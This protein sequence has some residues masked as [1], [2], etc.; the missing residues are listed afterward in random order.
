MATMN[1]ETLPSRAE[2]DV[3]ESEQ[4]IFNRLKDGPGT[5]GWVVLHSVS[6]PGRNKNSNPREI[7]FLIMVPGGGVICLEVKGDSYKI[8][9]DGKW[10]R[11]HGDGSAE[12]ESPINQ[13]KKAMDA[14]KAHLKRSAPAS[15]KQKI[16]RLP[17]W[18]GL[19]FTSGEWPKGDPRPGSL[20]FCD[21]ETSQDQRKLCQEL[22]DYAESLP[23]R[24]HDK[25][26][27]DSDTIAEILNFLRP[28]TKMEYIATSSSDLAEINGQLLKLTKEQFRA[29]R[30][31]QAD[32]GEIRNERVL[33]EGAAG[34]GKTMLAEQ[35]AKLRT[36]AGD[37]VALVFPNEVLA[38]WMRSK[39]PDVY[40]VGTVRDVLV[41]GQHVDESFREN[42]RRS[43]EATA[44]EV[45][46]ELIFTSHA[47]T[48]TEKM[49][50]KDLQWDYLIVD[51][52]QYFDY[53]HTLNMLDMALKGGLERGRWAMF[54]DFTFQNWS[55][56]MGR[57]WQRDWQR[58]V[59]TGGP[60]PL[61]QVVN[62]RECLKALCPGTNGGRGW[63]EALPLEINCRNTLPIAHAATRVVGIGTPQVR[64]SQVPG[65]PVD[66]YYWQE[67]SEM[68]SL[69]EE[70]FKR[71]HKAGVNPRQATVLSDVV[72][73]SADHGKWY[74]PWSLWDY[75]QTHVVR[76]SWEWELG[77]YVPN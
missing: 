58:G 27:L 21:R 71:L 68:R 33:F 77:Q 19:A 74:G 67:L 60:K 64:P 39:L 7:D 26:P 42:F 51:E 35:L 49:W 66:F 13:S 32:G 50:E 2:T 17:I 44:D 9:K 22:K 72:A 43:L 69:L 48:A 61:F 63:V 3:P 36:R 4:R 29:L 75:W 41:E 62:A 8:G 52:L 20:F 57:D 73:I 16:P 23:H 11:K 30:M 55:T 1:P 18:H 38:G 15:L 14:L 46:K 65:P 45:L 6:V 24:G 5:K 25:R 34:T 12:P 54:G 10:R 53:E 31:V 76:S 56:E 59:V 28:E 47:D 40:A 70:E 37:R